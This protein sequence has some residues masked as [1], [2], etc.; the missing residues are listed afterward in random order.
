[1]AATSFVDAAFGAGA[2]IGRYFNLVSVIPA[3]LFVLYAYA[4]AS[5]G[6]FDAEPAWG[7]AADALANIGLAEASLLIV[8]SFAVALVLHPL[9][10]ALLQLAEGYWGASRIA[11]RLALHRTTRHLCRLHSFET[12]RDASVG[13]LAD[14]TDD[15]L[16]EHDRV[17]P[18]L[19]SL[20]ARDAFERAIESYPRRRSLT[21]PTRL[22]NMLRRYE[23][24]AGSEYGL[25][26]LTVHP[27]LV[28]V[29]DKAHVAVLHE[30][31]EQLDLAVRLCALSLVAAV[32]TFVALATDGLWLLIALAPYAAAYT[33]YR[34]AIVAATTWGRILA[35]L[36]DVERFTLYQQLHMRLPDYTRDERTANVALMSLLQ[37]RGEDASMRYA[38][39][40]DTTLEV[41]TAPLRPGGGTQAGRS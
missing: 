13:P 25:D 24:L 4:L 33:A 20:L 29:G 36:I 2:R 37:S 9:Q 12:A 22:G 10:F 32:V 35:A 6:A 15:D 16:W 5:S 17:L 30:A 41:S 23:E 14:I 40:A 3:T 11:R 27:H 31:R 21:M 7:D 1:M 8:V 19:P 18:L 26:S 28:L 39:P 34:G 38:Y